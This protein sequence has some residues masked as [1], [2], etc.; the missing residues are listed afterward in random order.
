[1]QWF[2]PRSYKSCYNF[3]VEFWMWLVSL[4]L[5]VDNTRFILMFLSLFPT[6]SSFTTAFSVALPHLPCDVK[7]CSVV[8]IFPTISRVA[9][10]KGAVMQFR[11]V[12]KFWKIWLFKF[13]FISLLLTHLPPLFYSSL[14][15]DNQM[16]E[17]FKV[18]ADL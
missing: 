17:I 14:L 5:S 3:Q 2:I 10:S 1:M 16:D 13:L 6:R 12:Y 7:L 11:C 9:Q 15:E 8:L 18:T 4:W